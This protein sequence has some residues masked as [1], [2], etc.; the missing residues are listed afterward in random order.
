MDFQHMINLGIGLIL[1]IGGWFAREVWVA[2]K[3]LRNAIHRI[4]IEVPKG[5]VAKSEFIEA[6]REIKQEISRGFERIHD[7]LDHKEDKR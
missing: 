7:K 2:V 5:Y 6:V 3:D 4:E 1:S